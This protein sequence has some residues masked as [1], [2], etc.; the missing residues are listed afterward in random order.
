[1]RRYSAQGQRE[2]SL[3]KAFGFT[4]AASPADRPGDQSPTTLNRLPRSRG[5][6]S[7]L[8]HGLCAGLDKSDTFR[9]PVRM[10]GPECFL[11]EK[12]SE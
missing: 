12:R 10:S 3:E 9:D 6:S 11:F 7:S 8:S 4:C 1:M 5:A 2:V